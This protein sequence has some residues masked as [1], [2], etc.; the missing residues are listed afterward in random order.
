MNLNTKLESS[1]TIFYIFSHKLF[2]IKSFLLIQLMLR[3]VGPVLKKVRL[4]YPSRLMKSIGII[5][6]LMLDSRLKSAGMTV[7]VSL[8]LNIN[9]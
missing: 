3:T 5:G 4:S 6:Y 1:V 8:L 7:D 9:S 2:T